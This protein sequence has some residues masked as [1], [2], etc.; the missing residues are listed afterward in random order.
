[1]KSNFFVLT[2]TTI[3]SFNCVLLST[4]A[5]A[6]A[7]DDNQ[8]V[9]SKDDD[10]ANSIKKAI[11]SYENA[12]NSRDAKGLAKHWSKEGV[13]TS[14]LTGEQI[15]GRDALEQEFTS[16]FAEV[17]DS[18]LELATETIEFVSP[19]VAVEQG[20][21]T[22]TQP[23]AE[24]VISGYSVV[25]VKREGQ[26]LI[27]RVSEEEEPAPA[28]THYEQL[29]DLEW[30]I[31][32]WV[33]QDASGITIKTKCKWTRNQNFITRSFTSSNVDRVNITGMQF[34]GWDAAS[35]QIRSWAFDSDGGVAEG[36]WKLKG[37]NWIVKTTA[38]LPDGKKA[39]STTIFRP[40]D[41][42]S[43]GWQKTNRVVDGEILPNIAEVVIVRDATK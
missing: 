41:E 8:V 26:W 42:N 23:N 28:P 13:Y 30:I 18:K 17:K 24:P 36:I 34:V 37:K 35:K 31:G 3:V 19:N 15:V 22:V 11:K 32:D 16:L 29:K 9:A 43:F 25:Y 1:M 20:Q 21:A 6:I 40:L 33:D 27:D 39:S 4:A 14:Q 10:Q 7:N 12:F 38:T 2:L 5:K